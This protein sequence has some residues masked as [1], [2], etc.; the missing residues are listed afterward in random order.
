MTTT[1]NNGF[2]GPGTRHVNRYSLDCILINEKRQHV[3]IFNHYF[4]FNS[5]SKTGLKNIK[6]LELYI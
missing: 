1:D 5:I 4:Q 2:L 3:I 6:F